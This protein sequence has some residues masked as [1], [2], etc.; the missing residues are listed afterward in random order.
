MSINRRNFLLGSAAIG[1]GFGGLGTYFAYKH[2]TRGYKSQ[3]NGY[4]PLIEDPKGI[5]DLPEGFS[6]KILSKVGEIMDDGLPLPGLP[7]GMAAFP[8]SDGKVIVV[9][10]HETNF[11]HPEMSAF[12][13]NDEY[14]SKIPENKVFDLGTEGKRGNGGTSTFVYDLNSEKIEKQYLSLA[15]TLRN[16]CGGPTPWGSWLTCEETKAKAEDGLREN[17]G[18]VFEVPASEEIGLV[19]PIPLRGMGRIY[20]E[21]AAVDPTSG[22]VYLTEDEGDGIFYRYI[23]NT[24]GKLNEGGKLQALAIKGMPSID[25]RNWD[26]RVAHLNTPFDVEWIDLENIDNPNNDLRIRGHNKGAAILAR[27]E[28]LWYGNDELYISSTSGGPKQLGQIWRYIPSEF[29]GQEKE[30][31]SPG[32]LELFVE[33]QDDQLLQKCDNITVAPWGHIFVC[34]DGFGEDFIRAITNEGKVYTIAKN[35]ISSSEWAG[36]CFSPDGSTMFANIQGEGLTVSI[37]GPWDS[38]KI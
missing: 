9:R 24:P 12:G 21:A 29:E 7:D 20:R 15:G 11:S 38:F 5:I 1:I 16:C 36:V 35:A 18:Y 23:P 13:P 22:V 3:I 17:H 32:K 8:G 27:G 19:D 37:K 31:L 6:Y 25:L 14:L 26:E 2:Y 34:E 10:N 33:P 4:G 30:S 28:G